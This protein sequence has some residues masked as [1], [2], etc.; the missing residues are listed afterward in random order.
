M[1]S[2][3]DFII[4]LAHSPWAGVVGTV[5]GICLQA[6]FSRKVRVKVGDIEVEGQTEEQV[7]RLLKRAEELKQ[8]L[9][10]RVVDRP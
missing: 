3:L 2:Y 7:C 1:T 10:P 9:I 8:R 5:I 4:Q 6:R